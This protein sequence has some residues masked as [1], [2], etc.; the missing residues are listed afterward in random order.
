VSG[1]LIKSG[2]EPFG[3]WLYRSRDETALFSDISGNTE[4]VREELMRNKLFY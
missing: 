1:K 2:F 3:S 4:D